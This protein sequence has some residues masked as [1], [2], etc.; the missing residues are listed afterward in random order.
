MS[1]VVRFAVRPAAAIFHGVP[2]IFVLGLRCTLGLATPHERARV[3]SLTSAAVPAAVIGAFWFLR[4]DPAEA[5]P[6]PWAD[7][8][9]SVCNAFFGP[10][11]K[12]LAIVAV[13][14]GGL[15]FAFGEGGSKSAI[16]GL[17]FGA[18]LVLGAGNFL[19]WLGVLQTTGT[20]IGT[21]S[22]CG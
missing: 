19:Q 14:I 3:R 15:M 21:V 20:A 5:A 11:G 22:Q 4:P 8:V 6:N 13:V 2:A 16:A 9:E 12:G 10:I 1:A 17:I 7:G 18:G